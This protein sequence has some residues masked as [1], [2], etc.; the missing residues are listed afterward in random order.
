MLG[1]LW[2]TLFKTEARTV[3][4]KL[5]K[6]MEDSS[7]E[8]MVHIVPIFMECIYLKHRFGGFLK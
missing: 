2:G 5:L 4:G 7:H 6:R 3:D 1:E 8:L